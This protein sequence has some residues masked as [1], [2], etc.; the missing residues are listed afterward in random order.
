[1]NRTWGRIDLF[2]PK[3]L[4][5]L[6]RSQDRGRPYGEASWASTVARRLGVESSL[7]PVGRPKKT[8]EKEV[9]K[10]L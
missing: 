10:G 3:E 2:D 5:A 8:R 4:M 6:R 1:M 7:R 9:Q